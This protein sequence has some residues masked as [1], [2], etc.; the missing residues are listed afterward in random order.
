MM[1]YRQ[2]LGKYV[3]GNVVPTL[4]SSLQFPGC[5]P[6]S[7]AGFVDQLNIV[8]DVS[9]A[10]ADLSLEILKNQTT[11]FPNQFSWGMPDLYIPDPSI[12][13]TVPL[14]GPDSFSLSD[15]FHFYGS[16]LM[17]GPSAPGPSGETQY[18]PGG[19]SRVF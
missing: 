12:P 4:I 18:F 1:G 10:T 14:T 9:T 19:Q 13:V 8:E 3:P 2:N 15:E 7:D 17:P 11:S 6:R 5:G 16:S